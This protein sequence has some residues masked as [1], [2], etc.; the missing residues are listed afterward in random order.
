LK[1]EMGERGSE[2]G[3]YKENVSKL[4]STALTIELTINTLETAAWRD[5]DVVTI[6]TKELHGIGPWDV[7]PSTG[8]NIAPNAIDAW[9]S[10]KCPV[11]I[12]L[13]LKSSFNH[14]WRIASMAHRKSTSTYHSL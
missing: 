5:E 4:R 9:T 3:P 11:F 6:R 14:A 1:E 12:F 13:S 10:T 2:E 7:Y 8:H